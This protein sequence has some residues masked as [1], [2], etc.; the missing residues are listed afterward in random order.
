M[1]ADTNSGQDLVGRVIG[2]AMKVH[3]ALGPGFLE[4]VYANAL[5]I[6]LRLAGVSFEREKKLQVMYQGE[7]VGEF[8]CDF[9]LDGLVLELKAVTALVAA[10]EVQ[11]VN[12]LTVTGV[13]EG[14]L[15]NFGGQSL[16]FKKK[17]R[18]YR[19]TGKDR[20]NK[21]YRISE[22]PGDAEKPFLS[23][24]PVNPAPNTP[25]PLNSA[26]P[27]NPVNPVKSS[28]APPSPT[29][30]VN[31]VQK[32]FSL[33]ELLV[34]MA[35]LSI[36]VVMMLGL[37]SSATALWR[38]SENRADAYR[39]ARAAMGIISR[40]LTSALVGV[41]NTNFFIY[42][43]EAGGMLQQGGSPVFDSD[44]QALFFLGAFPMSAQETGSK[45][46]VCQVGYFVAFDRTA[47]S[48]NLAGSR[49]TMN[50][51]RYFLS[52]NETFQRL[53]NTNLTTVFTNNLFPLN[54]K[55]ELLARN[56]R[57]FR[58]TP[59]IV[60]NGTYSTNFTPATNRPLPDAVEISV[61]AVNQEAA[62]R[63]PSRED[64]ISGAE[65]LTNQQQTFTTRIRIPAGGRR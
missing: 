27:V 26:N 54:D 65:G 60:T 7:I 32:A 46:D 9:Y 37:V 22:Q 53:S 41:T 56:V 8:T 50:L 13:K 48:T 16:E 15:L 49:P 38:Q 4:S 34:A 11:L 57:E 36:L 58:V 3:R 6:E 23:A 33:L 43:N 10:H 29:H 12:Y 61:T 18:T 39:E 2:L 1:N 45:S 51:Y 62:K 59:L 55:V 14:L 47:I 40:D 17:F 63:F 64:W 24:N 44:R 5:E 52:S 28:F 21:I 31:P 35:V 20:I 42:G 19:D 30:P 25:G